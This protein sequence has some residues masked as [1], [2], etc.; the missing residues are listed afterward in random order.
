[1]TQLIYIVYVRPIEESN[2]PFCYECGDLGEIRV[3][4]FDSLDLAKQTI[5]R[6]GYQI[7]FVYDG[8]TVDYFDTYEGTDQH[9]QEWSILQNRTNTFD[10]SEIISNSP[11]LKPYTSDKNPH[12]T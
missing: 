3:G 5:A 12:A 1:M 2:L 6:H 11:N 7:E 10:T 9:G 4:I 8:E